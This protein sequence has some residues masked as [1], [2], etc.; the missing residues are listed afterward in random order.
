MIPKYKKQTIRSAP[1]LSNYN[2]SFR[3]RFELNQTLW[4][5]FLVGWNITIVNC[6]RC[7]VLR[8]VLSLNDK[9][10]LDIFTS[11]LFSQQQSRSCAVAS[12][13]AFSLLLLPFLFS[14]LLHACVLVLCVAF[15]L[16]VCRSGVLI[17]HLC[18]RV[19][20]VSGM[21]VSVVSEFSVS[22]VCLEASDDNDASSSSC[23]SKQWE[24]NNCSM[25]TLTG[26]TV[27]WD[28]RLVFFSV[29]VL[30]CV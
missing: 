7:A 5:S 24:Q 27:L 1:Y 26:V 13:D 14:S 12:D 3:V 16:T 8:S 9:T 11:I 18:L 15:E 29:H 25:Q 22:C 10:S 2:F 4:T 19:S 30:I 23:Q 6:P 20:V 21:G 17:C 28:Y